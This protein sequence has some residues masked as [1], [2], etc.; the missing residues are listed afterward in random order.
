VIYKF[1]QGNTFRGIEAQTAGEELER[2]RR[3]NGGELATE[4]VVAWAAE[5]DSPLHTAFTWDNERAGELYRLEE[6]RTLIR[7]VVV[8]GEEDSA[9]SPAFWNVTVQADAD[10]DTPAGKKQYYQ[11]SAVL[12]TNPD[13]FDSALRLMLRELASAEHG[14]EQLKRIAPRGRGAAISRATSHVTGARTELDK[15]AKVRG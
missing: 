5:S 13:E 15:L 10:G 6:A 11:S 1:K 2:I 4:Q 7:S 8:I 3:A 14:L 12:A 9:P